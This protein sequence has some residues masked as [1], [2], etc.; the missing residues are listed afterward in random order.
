MLQ[1]ISFF[2]LQEDASKYLPIAVAITPKGLHGAIPSPL[3]DFRFLQNIRWYGNKAIVLC[4]MLLCSHRLCGS[5]WA[6]LYMPIVPAV[7][8]LSAAHVRRSCVWQ[9]NERIWLFIIHLVLKSRWHVT[10]LAWGQVSIKHAINKAFAAV[11]LR[12]NT[13]QAGLVFKGLA[14]VQLSQILLRLHEGDHQE[15][16]LCE[17]LF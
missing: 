14:D 1:L 13:P 2:T 3:R 16:K 17:D 8:D 5:I 12:V 11:G 15:P 6:D 7:P 10:G 4:S 9:T